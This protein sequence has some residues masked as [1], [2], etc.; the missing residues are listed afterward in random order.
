MKKFKLLVVMLGALICFTSCASTGPKM[1]R[2]F[3]PQYPYSAKTNNIEGKVTLRFVVTTDGT[4][5]DAEV[6]E[7]SPEGVFEESALKS[8]ERS[9]FKPGTMAGKPV[10]TAM[11][12]T[13]VYSIEGEGQLIRIVD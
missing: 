7:S 10:G 9:Q 13:F 5:R 4:P 8:V 1:I 12:L 6:I 3:P 11:N 2:S